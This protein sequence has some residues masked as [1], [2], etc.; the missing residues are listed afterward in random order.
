M[1]LIDTEFPGLKV[2]EARRLGDDRGYFVKTFHKDT[3][4]AAGI[5]ENLAEVY[6]SSSHKGAVRGLHFQT[7]PH[8]HS[9]IVFCLQGKIFDAAVDLRKS[10]PTFGKAFTRELT[11]DEP[12]GLYIPAG[13]AHGFIAL[14]DDVLFMNATNTV[15][16]GPADGGIHWQS[17]GIA[18][19]D[20]PPIVSDKDKNLPAFADYESPFA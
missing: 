8:D 13:F 14:T 16:N 12:I 20:V 2:I 15:W 4:T 6:Y 9:K 10:S 5:D 7:P 18:W 17:C 19:P 11:G 3:L 1:K